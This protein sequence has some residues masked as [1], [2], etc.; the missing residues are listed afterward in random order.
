MV[1]VNFNTVDLLR[2]C[3]NSLAT[4]E[5]RAQVIV[6]DNASRDGSEI[7]V[8]QHFPEVQIIQSGQNAGFA[9]ANNLGIDRSTGEYVILLNSD[10]RLESEALTATADWMDANPSVG[11]TSPRLIGADDI[12]QTCQYPWPNARDLWRKA[13][14]LKIS[15]MK[16]TTGW[17]AGTCLVLR[18]VTLEQIGGHLDDQYWMYWEDADLS[19][20]I[21]NKGWLLK[22]FEGATVRHFGGASGGGA[23][24]TRRADLH[25]WYLY[26]KYHWFR[27]NKGLAGLLSVWILDLLDLPRKWMR[28]L[29]H[30]ERTAERAHAKVQAA[31]LWRFIKGV[32]PNVP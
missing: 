26:G 11:A 27:K 22:P 24:A 6:V 29:R 21:A 14:K 30:P 20:Q 16:I 17:L 4:F 18:R 1:V 15:P 13:L 7:M 32:R 28:S 2:Q 19:R 23:D 8:S 3:L 5:P 9:A 31:A 10:T 25:A 12:L